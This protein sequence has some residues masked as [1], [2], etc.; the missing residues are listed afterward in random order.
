M[1]KESYSKLFQCIY[2]KNCFSISQKNRGL[3]FLTRQSLCQSFNLSVLI[4]VRLFLFVTQLLGSLAKN[5][6]K[7]CSEQRHN[8]W[9]CKFMKFQFHYFGGNLPLCILKFGNLLAKMFMNEIPNI[10]PKIGTDTKRK[11]FFHINRRER[12]TGTW[13]VY[14]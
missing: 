11:S 4:F 12:L 3:L 8:V 6:I 14:F 2:D 1:L 10:C 13:K 7:R 5:V 9:I